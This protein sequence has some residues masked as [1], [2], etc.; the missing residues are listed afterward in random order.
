[1]RQS[2]LALHVVVDQL[3]LS[4]LFSVYRQTR[5]YT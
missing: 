5:N 1:V 2:T 3:L 4:G